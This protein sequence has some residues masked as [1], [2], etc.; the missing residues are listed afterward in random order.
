MEDFGLSIQCTVEHGYHVIRL[1]DVIFLDDAEA[2]LIRA[3]IEETV[4]DS[5]NPRVAVSVKGIKVISTAAWGKMMVLQRNL[6]RE[7]GALA[8]LDVGDMIMDVLETMKLTKLFDIRESVESLEGPG[9][10]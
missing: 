2:Q 8:L 5:G 10:G 3:R 7:G 1:A 9:A 4:A 6:A